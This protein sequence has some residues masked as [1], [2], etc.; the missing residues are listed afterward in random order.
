MRADEGHDPSWIILLL[1]KWEKCHIAHFICYR[2]GRWTERQSRSMSSSRRRSRE[3]RLILQPSSSSRRKTSWWEEE[4]ERLDDFT[5]SLFRAILMRG[6]NNR[7]KAWPLFRTRRRDI[8]TW[9]PKLYRV[10]RYSFLHRISVKR[11]R[12]MLKTLRFPKPKDCSWSKTH[13]MPK[14]QRSRRSTLTLWIKR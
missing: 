4:K 7:S 8:H 13:W 14:S 3:L 11:K 1:A 2:T 10:S 5:N 6:S 9:T 12:R